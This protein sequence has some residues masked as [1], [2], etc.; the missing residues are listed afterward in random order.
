MKTSDEIRQ[1]LWNLDGSPDWIIL[2]GGNPALHPLTDFIGRLHLDGFQVAVE[3]QGDRAPGWFNDVDLLTVSPKPPSS[4]METNWHTLDRVVFDRKG[5]IDL[6]V[7]AFTPEDLA[8]AKKV[9]TR[10]PQLGTLRRHFISTG[11]LVGES[12]RDD[13]LDR[14]RDF[15]TEGLKD[16]ILGKATYGMQLHVLL[17]GHK[18]G[19]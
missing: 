10:Y 1:D 8:Y 7:V 14:M 16:P 13:I 15:I 17:H 3:T 5:P 9:F 6:K 18:R 19:V 11:T 4:L 2:S 12:T